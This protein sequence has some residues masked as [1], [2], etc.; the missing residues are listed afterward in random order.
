MQDIW[1]CFSSSSA[2][3][4]P[5]RKEELDLHYSIQQASDKEM[6]FVAK[7]P[8]DKIEAVDVIKLKLWM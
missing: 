3:P 1:K 6:L 2:D 4:S 5:E 7:L 8:F